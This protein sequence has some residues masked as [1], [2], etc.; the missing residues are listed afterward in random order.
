MC[1]YLHAPARKLGS[2]LI[3]KVMLFNH[4]NLLSGCGAC[5]LMGPCPPSFYSIQSC[6]TLLY[7]TLWTLQAFILSKELQKRK[8]R[9][10]TGSF[11]G[12]R[13][14]TGGRGGHT[15]AGSISLHESAES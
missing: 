11:S 5:H 10:F 14:M 7:H 2:P 4:I 8:G 3:Q 15:S 1:N 9:A 12:I 13:S 6:H